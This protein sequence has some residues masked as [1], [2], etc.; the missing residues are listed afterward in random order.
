MNILCTTLYHFFYYGFHVVD[1]I[2]GPRSR[3]SAA[4]DHFADKQIDPIVIIIFLSV[5]IFL[6][7]AM[8]VQHHKHMKQI[9]EHNEEIIKHHQKLHDKIDEH[10]NGKK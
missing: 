2:T 8:L 10:I 1:K 9:S 3:Y 5:I 6:L 7:L 4:H